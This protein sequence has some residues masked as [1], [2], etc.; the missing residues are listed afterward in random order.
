MLKG[1]SL[2]ISFFFEGKQL[3]IPLNSTLA[4]NFPQVQK[5]FLSFFDVACRNAKA[6]RFS[7]C[8]R[9]KKKKKNSISINQSFLHSIHSFNSLKKKKE[10]F[11][12]DHATLIQNIKNLCKSKFSHVQFAAR[13]LFSII[14]SESWIEF[15]Y[16]HYRSSGDLI[17]EDLT[18]PLPLGPS[19]NYPLM[20]SLVLG[21]CSNGLDRVTLQ[22]MPNLGFLL[23]EL[24]FHKLFKFLINNQN[25]LD[26]VILFFFG[27]HFLFFLLK[28]SFFFCD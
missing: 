24:F 13:R 18:A 2:F 17:F 16:S 10:L 11:K 1:V 5:N 26:S 8:H 21:L 14:Q 22:T 15:A 25:Q 28:I 20:P 3:K 23:D 12:T 27:F 7:R 9:N 4:R 19:Q 6:N